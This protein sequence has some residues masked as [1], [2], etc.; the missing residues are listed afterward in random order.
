MPFLEGSV[1]TSTTPGPVLITGGRVIDPWQG[2]DSIA[3]V[4]VQDGRV[5]WIAICG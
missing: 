1:V 2:L 5:A 3:D 4:L